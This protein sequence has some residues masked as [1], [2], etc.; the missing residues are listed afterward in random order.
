MHCGIQDGA[1]FALL[2]SHNATKKDNQCSGVARGPQYNCSSVEIG[3]VGSQVE[4]NSRAT[5]ACVTKWNIFRVETCL[6]SLHHDSDA[7]CQLISDSKMQA[8]RQE[9]NACVDLKYAS[10]MPPARKLMLRNIVRERSTRGLYGT[11][12]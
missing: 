6:R 4:N 7:Q 3:S 1:D 10:Q 9:K 11:A 8:S 5:R 2:R 12:N